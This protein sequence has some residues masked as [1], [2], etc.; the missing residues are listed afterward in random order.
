MDTKKYSEKRRIGN[1]GE[2]I[3]AMFLVKQG[4]RI[5]DRNYLKKW[6]EIDLILEIDNLIRFVEVKTQVT[7]ENKAKDVSRNVSRDC[8][9]VSDFQ[10]LVSRETLDDD[11]YRP[12]DN[13]HYWKQKRLIRAIETYLMER[14]I[15]ENKEWQIDVVTVKIDF[16]NKTAIIKHIENVVFDV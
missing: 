16:P 15:D 6:G 11:I 7:R 1:I 13:V 14:N 8:F 9:T 3:V 2:D 4:Y 10:M 12:E 5:L